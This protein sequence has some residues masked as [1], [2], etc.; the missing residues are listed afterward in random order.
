MASIGHNELTH[1][2]LVIIGSGNGLEPVGFQAIIWTSADL[3]QIKPWGTG[4]SEIIPC[5]SECFFFLMLS[6][7]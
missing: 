3:L 1:S 5:V 6:T 7:K 4:L 2:G